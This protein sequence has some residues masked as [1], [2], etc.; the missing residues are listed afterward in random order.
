MIVDIGTGNGRAVLE[1]AAVEPSA[2]VLGVDAS[3]AAMVESSRRAARR[4]PPNAL[5]FAVGAE[6]L[7]ESPLAGQADIVTVTFPWGSLLRGV[8]GLDR[9]AL[10]GV[11][12]VL[13]PDGMLQVLAS[14]MPSDGVFRLDCLDAAAAP[15]VRAAWHAAG[16]ELMRFRPAT[17]DEITGSGSSWARRLQAAARDPTRADARSVW[18]LDGRRLG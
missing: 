2:L 5:F 8:L 9:P 6:R 17:P 16:L 13:R 4:G 15:A 18:R 3:A 10:D 14:V 7:A 12:S 1:R 11:A